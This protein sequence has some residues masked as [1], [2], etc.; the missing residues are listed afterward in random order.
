MRSEIYA[1]LGEMGFPNGGDGGAEE[2]LMLWRSWYEGSVK[3]FHSYR[4]YNGQKR[5]LCRRAGLGMAKKICE[6]WANL[7]MNE[8]VRIRVEGEREAAF[9][10]RILTENSFFAAVN[11]MQELKAALGTAAYVPRMTDGKIRI[12]CIDAEGIL[13]LS[14]ENGTV[15]DCA[16]ASGLRQGDRDLLYLQLH[17]RADG[18]Y[19]IE[20]LVF[21]V[22]EDRLRPLNLREVS[23]FGEIPETVCTGRAERSFVLD[24]MNI[25][26]NLEPG[27][28]MGLSV[29]ANALDQLRGADVA[30]DSYVNEFI[31]GKKRIM[32]KPEATKDFDGAPLF[33][34][35][36]LA[37]Y[38]LPEDSGNESIIKEI[39]MTLRTAEHHEGIQDMLNLL[40]LKCGLGEQHY[41][42]ERGSVLT[43]TQVISENSV[44]YRN[45]RRHELV[46][47]TALREL[48][49]ILLRMGNDYFGLGLRE[50]AAVTVDF[51]D[52]I[53][54]DKSRDFERDCRM[55][56][57]GVMGKEAFREKWGMKDEN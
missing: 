25:V 35:D 33:D 41:R 50:D 6:D 28:P 47:E 42:F 56:E 55:L 52:S 48:I 10:D 27:S 23:G 12:D 44:L 5:I 38:I 36:E 11:R 37:F 54:E 31:L 26:N 1:V 39:D 49:G 51:D 20:N 16:F 17:H 4:V 40:G 13:P 34:A 22:E 14:W 46:L 7:L 3:H 45:V 24:R 53:I 29:F 15:N 9:I 21:A 8:R 30:Y 57:L 19:R 2:L 18:L 32:L 43:A